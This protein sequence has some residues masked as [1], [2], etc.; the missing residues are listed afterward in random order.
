[1]FMPF[2]I[3]RTARLQAQLDAA[4]DGHV[5]GVGTC[6]FTMGIARPHPG[7][8]AGGGVVH[9]MSGDPHGVRLMVSRRL[10]PCIWSPGP[11]SMGEAAPM[12]VTPGKNVVT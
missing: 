12:S 8:S 10:T 11:I 1:M 6:A 5:R 9:H 4:V 3:R 7:G 2:G